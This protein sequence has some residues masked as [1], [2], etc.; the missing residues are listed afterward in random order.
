MN[1]RDRVFLPT[2]LAV[3]QI[4]TKYDAWSILYTN[5]L[6]NLTLFIFLSAEYLCGGRFTEDNGHFTSPFFPNPYPSDISCIYQL[7]YNMKATK[8]TTLLDSLQVESQI[9]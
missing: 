9:I 2:Y 5:N 6:K 1:V 8:S 4:L 3:V 7:R